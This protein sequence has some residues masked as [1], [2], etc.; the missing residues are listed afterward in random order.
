MNNL[1]K[2]QWYALAGL[3]DIWLVMIAYALGGMHPPQPDYLL[4]LLSLIVAG[5]GYCLGRAHGGR[6]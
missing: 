2:Q 4:S 1:Y 6:I 5:T 3:G